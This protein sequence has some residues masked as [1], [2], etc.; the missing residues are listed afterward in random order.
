MG[1]LQGQSKGKE[2]GTVFLP[3]CRPE[4]MG[5]I[6]IRPCGLV[7][8]YTYST[9]TKRVFHDC[10]LSIL[11]CRKG[12]YW[13]DSFNLITGMLQPYFIFTINI[14]F[15]NWSFCWTNLSYSKLVQEIF[16]FWWVFFCCIENF[17]SF[18]FVFCFGLQWN[19]F[20]YLLT[21]CKILFFCQFFPAAQEVY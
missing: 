19:G 16:N 13:F 3:M 8:T 4:K 15:S 5:H 1:L 9:Y 2:A 17:I 11:K 20:Q 18:G 21:V 12:I 6:S 10:Q 7:S 14:F